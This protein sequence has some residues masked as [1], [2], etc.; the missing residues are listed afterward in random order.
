MGDAQH[1][2]ARVFEWAS[3]GRSFVTGVVHP[4]RRVDNKLC[5]WKYTGELMYEVPCALRDGNTHSRQ[6]RRKIFSN[7]IHCRNSDRLSEMMI[8]KLQEVCENNVST[9]YFLLYYSLHL[10]FDPIRR[11][12]PSCTSARTARCPRATT[13]TARSRRNARRRRRPTLTLRVLHRLPR[14]EQERHRRLPPL[15]QQAQQAQPPRYLQPSRPLQP[16]LRPHPRAPTCRRTCATR[17]GFQMRGNHSMSDHSYHN[18]GS[19]HANS[20]L[21]F[22]TVLFCLVAKGK[23]E[24]SSQITYIFTPVI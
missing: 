6:Q 20:F 12:P 2:S 13:P 21:V 1:H 24:T 7:R 17:H 8:Q 18:S 15:Q 10:T 5:V 14:P 23:C 4:Y 16:P 19:A 3:D 9:P 22:I 11:R